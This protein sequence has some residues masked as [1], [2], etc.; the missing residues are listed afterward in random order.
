MK[1]WMNASMVPARWPKV[2]PSSTTRHSSWWN[3]ARWVESVA[4]LRNTR[5]GMIE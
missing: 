5:P 1:A 4:S 2:M 3:T